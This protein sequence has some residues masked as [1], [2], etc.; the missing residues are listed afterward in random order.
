M[1]YFRACIY[2]ASLILLNSCLGPTFESKLSSSLQTLM[3]NLI[4]GSFPSLGGQGGS[5]IQCGGGGSF[6]ATNPSYGSIDPLNPSSTQISTPII[7]KDCVIEV[8]GAKLEL[9]G[10]G[11][12]IDLTLGDL[13]EIGNSQSN[14][15]IMILRFE[16]QTFRQIIE[17]D[18]SFSYQ[19]RADL[20]EN[21][22]N[23]IVIEDVDPAEPLVLKGKSFEGAKIEKWADGC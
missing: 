14:T 11:T 13:Q 22:L 20:S 6:R 21:T 8:C 12:Y 17:G 2:F 3:A 19:M 23:S 7:F 9:D 1:T 18:F 15:V 4:E 10:G 5:S 16:Q